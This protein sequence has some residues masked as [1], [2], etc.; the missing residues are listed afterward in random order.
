MYQNYN[1]Y[2]NPLEY[3]L[4]EQETNNKRESK[5]RLVAGIFVGF[6]AGFI[7]YDLYQNWKRKEELNIKN[8][9]V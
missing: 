5:S 7:V 1:N 4:K 6:I 9:S 2:H 8:K 3:H